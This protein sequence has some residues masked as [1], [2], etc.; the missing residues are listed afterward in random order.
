MYKLTLTKNYNLIRKIFSNPILAKVTAQPEEV[1]R[2][3]KYLLIEH[4]DNLMGCF[5]FRCFTSQ[6]VECH[7]NILPEFW[8]KNHALDA[9]NAGFDWVRKNTKFS[10]CFTDVPVVCVHVHKLCKKIGWNPCGLIR[11]G[12][13]YDGKLTDLILY[14]YDLKRTNNE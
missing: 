8:G 14:D 2:S 5:T 1:D 10:K 12:C 6:I 3:Y 13:M 11:E 9:S 4:N 7:I